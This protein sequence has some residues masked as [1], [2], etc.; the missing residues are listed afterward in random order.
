MGNARGGAL[1]D[2]IASVLEKAGYDVTREFY[3]NDAGNQI[4]RF[5]LSLEARYLQHFLGEDKV[6]FPEDGYHG[7]DI[8]DHVKSYIEVHGD[9]LLSKTPEERRQ[10]LVDYALPINIQRIRDALSDYGIEYDV[11]FSEKSLHDSG[12]VK[13]TVDFLKEKG[14]N[15]EE[16]AIWLNGEIRS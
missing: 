7:E 4:E 2:C 3:I 12:A 8:I 10:I 13:E 1:G 9:A 15:R 5:G 16:G 6:A 11:W 14:Y